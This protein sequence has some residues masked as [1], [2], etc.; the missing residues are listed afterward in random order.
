MRKS[1]H[2]VVGDPGHLTPADLAVH[3]L[4]ESGLG[5]RVELA[6]DDAQPAIDAEVHSLVYIAYSVDAAKLDSAFAMVPVP[7]LA[8]QARVFPLLGLC[9][10]VAAAG[11]DQVF[12]CVQICA[13]FV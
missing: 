10:G 3:Q 2:M 7:V 9:D 12:S 1:V 8:S 11:G 6:D 5:L 13:G 4:L